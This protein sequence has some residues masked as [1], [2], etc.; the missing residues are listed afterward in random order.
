MI[1]FSVLDSGGNPD[2]SGIFSIVGSAVEVNTADPAKIGTY[3]MLLE[4]N[5]GVYD[6][7]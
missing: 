3:N 4:G 2:T 5:I 7:V 6:T 1:A